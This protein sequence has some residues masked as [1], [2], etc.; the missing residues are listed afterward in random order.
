MRLGM[1]SDVTGGP[2]IDSPEGSLV[3]E[4]W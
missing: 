2:A 4:L 1:I 3:L